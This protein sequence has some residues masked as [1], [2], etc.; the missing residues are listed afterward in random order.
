MGSKL[1]VPPLAQGCE[2]QGLGKGTAKQYKQCFFSNQFLETKKLH[3]TDWLIT[4]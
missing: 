2:L 4:S 1:Q 3:Y